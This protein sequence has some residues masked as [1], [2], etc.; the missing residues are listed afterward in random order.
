[1]QIKYQFNIARSMNKPEI[2]SFKVGINRCYIIRQSGSIMI[3]GGSPNEIKSIEKSIKSFGLKPDEIKL[4]VL[5]HGHFDHAGSA[6]DIRDLT[7][8]RLMIHKEDN[9]SIEK[10]EMIWPTGVNRWGKF[11]SSIFKIILVNKMKF[12][13]TK[14][15]I[16]LDTNE[17]SLHDY[18]VEGKVVHTPGHTAGSLSV[19][20]D[21]GDAFVGCMAHNNPPFRLKPGYPIYANDIELLKKSWEV[22][23]KMGAKT[24]YPGHGDPFPVKVIEKILEKE[25][26]A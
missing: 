14:A 11:T 1:M 6:G 20:L 16:I 7:G 15:D 9:D 22:L 12:P 26:R 23:I 17:F 13:E 21:T 5:T 18:G 8:A 4:V 3:D 2:F 19:L 10:S 25:K 24:I